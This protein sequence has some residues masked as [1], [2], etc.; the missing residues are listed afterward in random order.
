MKKIDN[1]ILQ[2]INKMVHL[3]S[4]KIKQ[5]WLD[6]YAKHQN[7]IQFINSPE[8]GVT[9]VNSTSGLGMT[10]SFGLTEAYW[11]GEIVTENQ[12]G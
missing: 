5:R 8:N 2:E 7:L 10:L 1:L 9:I 11:R 4:K 3:P 6:L 12:P